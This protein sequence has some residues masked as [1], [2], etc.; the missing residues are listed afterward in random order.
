[1]ALSHG[2]DFA[3]GTAGVKAILSESGLQPRRSQEGARTPRRRLVRANPSSRNTRTRRPR[4][5]FLAILN[6]PWSAT[7]CRI[8]DKRLFKQPSQLLASR[9][10]FPRRIGARD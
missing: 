3:A 6:P 8:C 4:S 10:D 5:F 7:F 9:E 2:T 1:M